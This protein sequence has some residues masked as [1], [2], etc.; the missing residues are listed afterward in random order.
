[1]DF[2]LISPILDKVKEDN[3][4]KSHLILFGTHISEGHGYTYND[5]RNAGY[6][7]DASAQTLYADD[8]SRGTA[9]TFAKT[10]EQLA[11]IFD[12]LKPDALVIAGDRYEMLAA[13]GVA[14]VM[15][16]VIIHLYGGDTSLGAYDEQIR[17]ALT[18]LSHLHF[19]S[20]DDSL[21]RVIQMGE[22]PERVY[23]FGSPSLDHLNKVQFINKNELE[24][25]LGITFG[26]Q[27]YLFTYHPVTRGET[28]ARQ[29]IKEI[30]SALSELPQDVHLFFTSPNADTEGRIILDEITT[31]TK[32]RAN[33]WLFNSLGTQRFFSMM[34]YVDGIIGNSSSGLYEA[35]SFGIPTIN[36]G[37]RQKG[38]LAGNSV[39]HCACEQKAILN[40]IQ[41]SKTMNCSGITN[42]Y[43]QDGNAAEK[44][45]ST[46][47]EKL[48]LDKLLVKPFHTL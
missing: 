33:S 11:E 18:K 28:G 20:N 30:L 5:V 36:I 37:E 46:I 35:P 21:K 34:K 27:N 10:A 23:N 47:K 14:T 6:D 17:H 39:I 1:M 25:N 2:G 9:L 41:Q 15:N 3:K 44:I 40:S 7:I 43:F 12:D 26:A 29:E 38:R 16:I 32:D 22:L 4:L 42:P 31:F 45:I 19:V 24:K 48:P 8:S 13:A